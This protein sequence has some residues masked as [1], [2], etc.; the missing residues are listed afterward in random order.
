MVF[1][2]TVSA[3]EAVGVC[4]WRGEGRQLALGRVRVDRVLAAVSGGA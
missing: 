3:V 1:V 4:E 2:A